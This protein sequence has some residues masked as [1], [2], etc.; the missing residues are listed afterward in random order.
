MRL[1]LSEG[2]AELL[3]AFCEASAFHSAVGPQGFCDRQG[4]GVGFSRG[5]M[6]QSACVPYSLKARRYRVTK[7]SGAVS[8]SFI[9]SPFYHGPGRGSIVVGD[10]PSDRRLET[11]A[12]V[13]E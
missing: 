5:R 10:L 12:R 2:S 6:F 1:Q 4:A 3:N 13:T 9:A 11:L 8:V 7:S